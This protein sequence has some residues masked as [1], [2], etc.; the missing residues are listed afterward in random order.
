MNNVY[1]QPEDFGLKIVAEIDYT[2]GCYQFDCRVVWRH[3]ESDK[4][5]TARDSGCSCPLPFK[6]YTKLEDL[7]ELTDM[8]ALRNEVRSADLNHS[9]LEN[10]QTFLDKV[11]RVLRQQQRRRA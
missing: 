10:R 1:Y 3:K 9:T 4:L 6:D 11:G 8:A 5:Y 2:D 7:Y